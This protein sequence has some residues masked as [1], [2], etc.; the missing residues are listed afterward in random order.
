MKKLWLLAIVCMVFV[1]G[2]GLMAQ[3]TQAAYTPTSGDLIKIAN[4]GAIYYIG[5]DNMRHLYVNEATFW[6]WNTG[7]WS[8]IKSN[9]VSE[10]IRTI[11]QAD[12]DNLAVG[13]NV[14]AKPGAK[15]VKFENSPK[16][17]TVVSNGKLAPVPDDS[18]AKQLFGA[19]WSKKII[20]IQNGF[21]TDYTKDGQLALPVGWKD[22][23]S[24]YG[25]SIKFP[26][27]LYF[28]GNNIPAIPQTGSDFGSDLII[29]D[30]QAMGVQDVL[31]SEKIHV[32]VSISKKSATE[33][34]LDYLKREGYQDSQ[35]TEITFNNVKSYKIVPTSTQPFISIYT[36]NDTYVY[37]IE[38][39]N[40]SGDSID[41][42]N[43]KLM[44]QIIDT[45]TFN[46]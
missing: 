5:A 2:L 29:S 32:T 11:S 20:T 36:A 31:P 39:I 10:V 7:S 34:L 38:G 6:T 22:Y 43:F 3:P 45:F 4:N 13:K 26:S 12:F 18:A 35:I 8:N 40:Y 1:F 24:T 44:Q 14:T 21:E 46:Y 15:L 41:S 17:Y 37:D 9:G 23:S 33:S 30:I 42:D 28:K 25:F 27:N 16:I 19:D